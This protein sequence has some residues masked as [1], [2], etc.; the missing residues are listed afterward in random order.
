MNGPVHFD[1]DAVL[2]AQERMLAAQEKDHADLVGLAIQ[3]RAARG[4]GRAVLKFLV[5]ERNW[6]TD[7]A[8]V[9]QGFAILIHNAVEMLLQNYPQ[10]YV[11]RVFQQALAYAA[12]PGEGIEAFAEVYGTRGGRA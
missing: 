1:V 2:A 3:M 10:P 5:E 12:G 9:A 6:G 8:E 11:D 4:P 7:P